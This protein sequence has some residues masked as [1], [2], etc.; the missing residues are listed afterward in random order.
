MPYGEN[1]KAYLFT[2]HSPRD[3][4]SGYHNIK[5][6]DHIIAVDNG[7]KHLD[8]LGLK[9]EILVGDQDSVEP[10]LLKKYSQTPTYLFP[11]E[12]NETDTELAFDWC[13][14]HFPDSDIIICNDFQGRFDHSLSVALLLLKR[15]LPFA[16]KMSFPTPYRVESENQTVFILPDSI[17]FVNCSGKLLSLLPLSPKIEFAFSQNLKYPLTD[18]IIRN[19]QSRGVSNVITSDRANIIK[20]EGICLAVLTN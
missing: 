17:E 4:V 18:L 14:K 16:V 11:S 2:N 15:Q 10:A 7:L 9:P 20:K 1:S 3:I 8:E 12:K 5:T 6:T 19:Y 13:H